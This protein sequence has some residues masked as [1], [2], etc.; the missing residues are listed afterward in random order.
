MLMDTSHHQSFR[1]VITNTQQLDE[2]QLTGCQEIATQAMLLSFI[3]YSTEA[4]KCNDENN[5][6]CRLE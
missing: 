2:F 1:K 3:E 4:V 6:S 5:N